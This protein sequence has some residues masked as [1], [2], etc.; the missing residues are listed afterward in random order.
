VDFITRNSIS[1]FKESTTS[2]DYTNEQLQREK[3][4]NGNKLEEESTK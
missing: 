1:T 3:I 2:Q 4:N